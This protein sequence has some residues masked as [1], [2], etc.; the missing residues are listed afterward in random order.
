MAYKSSNWERIFQ[1]WIIINCVLQLIIFTSTLKRTCHLRWS[2][3][4][5]EWAAITSSAVS[6]RQS[7]F[8]LTNIYFNSAL[9]EPSSYSKNSNFPCQKLQVLVVSPIKAIL[10]LASS[11]RLERLP[12]TFAKLHG[13]NWRKTQQ[14]ERFCDSNLLSWFSKLSRSLGLESAF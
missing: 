3:R 10:Q 8:L 6:K 9:I 11:N 7:V 2:H 14:S 12:G 4:W 5:L 13:N 1:V